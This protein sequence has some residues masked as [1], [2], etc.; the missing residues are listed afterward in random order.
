MMIFLRSSPLLNYHSAMQL[1]HQTRQNRFR[2]EVIRYGSDV[3][4][5]RILEESAKFRS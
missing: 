4:L 2:I 5:V 1:S 3:E